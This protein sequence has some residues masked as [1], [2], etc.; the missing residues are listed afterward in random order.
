MCVCVCV[1]VCVAVVSS[2]SPTAEDFAD[3]NELADEVGTS[4]EVMGSTSKSRDVDDYGGSLVAEDK[5]DT[6]YLKGMAFAQAQLSASQSSRSG[7]IT[8]STET[9]DYD[10]DTEEDANSQPLPSNT[11][12]QEL[13]LPDSGYSSLPLSDPTAIEPLTS[14]TN[15]TTL[16]TQQPTAQLTTPT[17]L[18]QQ[19]LPTVV[20]EDVAM[21]ETSQENR[22]ESAIP[23]LIPKDMTLDQLH[24]K[25][26]TY[27]M[28]IIH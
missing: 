20:V 1:C 17:S 6:L 19:A 25:V 23:Y 4:S 11:N 13:S 7:L 9:D 12:E 27:S 28:Y 21:N 16:L 24:M 15:D 26:Y 3:I 10:M 22:I 14:P 18:T 5:D 8:V 2:K